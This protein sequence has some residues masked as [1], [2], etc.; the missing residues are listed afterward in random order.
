[1]NVPASDESTSKGRVGDDPD[2]KLS[3]S[4]DDPVRLDRSLEG[5]VLHLSSDD[6]LPKPRNGFRPP[7]SRNTAL[8]QPNPLHGTLLHGR[9]ERL[10]HGLDRNG[11]VDTVLVVQVDVVG[12]Q[13]LQRVLEAANDVFGVGD[14]GFASLGVPFVPDTKLGGQ[15]DLRTTSGFREPRA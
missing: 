3:T 15:E 4:I 7:K 14:G 11:R 12:L 1:M 10:Q 9:P 6:L 8:A 2:T 5:T 13:I